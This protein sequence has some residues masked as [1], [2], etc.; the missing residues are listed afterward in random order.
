ML[1]RDMGCYAWVAFKD[2]PII[3]GCGCMRGDRIGENHRR[4]VEFLRGHYG[5]DPTESL[6]GEGCPGSV[7]ISPALATGWLAGHAI[8]EGIAAGGDVLERY[9]E[10][11]HAERE[12]VLDE[13]SFTRLFRSFS[14]PLAFASAFGRHPWRHNPG[15][16]RDTYRFL[17]Q[18]ARSNGVGAAMVHNS[19]QRLLA[20]RRYEVGRVDDGRV[21]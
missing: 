7:G 10:A 14:H 6:R 21:S 17:D 4:F 9:R 8:A 18:Q 12:R 1:T 5:F 19:W 2:D 3:V 15:L 20:R 13:W 11:T 16:V